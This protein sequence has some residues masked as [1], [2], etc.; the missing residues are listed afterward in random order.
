MEQY[1]KFKFNWK[2]FIINVLMS[3]LCLFIVL[4]LAKQIT[5]EF[6]FSLTRFK[7]SLIVTAIIITIM[8]IFDYIKHKRKIKNEKD[9]W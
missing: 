6:G 3:I 7:Y 9:K 8:L 4:I 5:V 1:C 2:I